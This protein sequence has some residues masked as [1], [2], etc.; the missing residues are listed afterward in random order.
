[1]PTGQHL[2][3][4]HPFAAACIITSNRKTC[5]LALEFHIDKSTVRKLRRGVIRKVLY[6]QLKGK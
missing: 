1:M 5:E 3:S 6:R 4:I 2:V